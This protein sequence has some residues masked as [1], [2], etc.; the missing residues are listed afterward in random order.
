VIGFLLQKRLGNEHRHIYVLVTELLELGVKDALDIFPNCV[1]VGADDH[2][3]LNTRIVNQLRLLN[4]VG[5]PL[6]KIC[7]H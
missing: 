7:F 3:S 2:T 6:G 4:D 1:S 5:I